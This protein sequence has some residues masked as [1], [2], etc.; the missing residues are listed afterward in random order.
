MTLGLC[1]IRAKL[2]SEGLC[3]WPTEPLRDPQGGPRAPFEKPCTKYPH[4]VDKEFLLMH[5]YRDLYFEV[6][7]H[8]RVNTYRRPQVVRPWPT[9]STAPCLKTQL[10]RGVPQATS[11][12]LF[13]PHRCCT[14]VAS[15]ALR[16]FT[17]V[18]RRFVLSSQPQQPR[19]GHFVRSNGVEPELVSP[20][21]W[22]FIA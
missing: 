16:R 5:G 2:P 9:F 8:G 20:V 10:S 7:V 4:T 13:P 21:P 17:F 15:I 6:H 18:T 1:N 3:F 19:K 12:L 14:R 11:S 22:K